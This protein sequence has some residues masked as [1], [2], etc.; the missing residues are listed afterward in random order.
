[1][2]SGQNMGV[3]WGNFGMDSNWVMWKDVWLEGF[4]LPGLGNLEGWL[5]GS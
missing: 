3:F 2:S 4:D 1:M 5:I